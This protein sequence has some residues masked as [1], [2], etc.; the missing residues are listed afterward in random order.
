MTF[1]CAH[2][3]QDQCRKVQVFTVQDVGGPPTLSDGLPL[4]LT[5]PLHVS[6]MGVQDAGLGARGLWC[7]LNAMEWEIVRIPF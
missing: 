3:S 4:P 2:R 5:S 7:G 1:V 6:D